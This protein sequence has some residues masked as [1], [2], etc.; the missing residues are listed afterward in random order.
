MLNDKAQ[1][2]NEDKET[3]ARDIGSDMETKPIKTKYVKHLA[4]TWKRLD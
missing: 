2:L 1:W 3:K 4:G